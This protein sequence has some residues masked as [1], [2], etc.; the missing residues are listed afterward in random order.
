M[1]EK[2]I[3]AYTSDGSKILL[4]N[5]NA[6]E[7]KF[8]G[9]LWRYQK[10]LDKKI[11]TIRDKEFIIGNQLDINENNKFKYFSATL[12]GENCYG[13]FEGTAKFIIANYGDFWAYGESITAARAFLGNKLFNLYRDCVYSHIEKES[14]SK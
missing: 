1:I 14:I 5:L 9:G 8:S 3:F 10:P 6:N 2:E 7:V 13:K 4:R 11:K 12:V